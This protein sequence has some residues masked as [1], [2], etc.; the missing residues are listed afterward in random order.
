MFHGAGPFLRR[1]FPRAHVWQ[2]VLLGLALVAAGAVL[3]AAGGVRAGLIGLVGVLILVAVVLSSIPGR[4][5][6][7]RR[8]AGMQPDASDPAE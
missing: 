7:G 2:R 5:A 1:W 8:G 6:R 4:R 3:T